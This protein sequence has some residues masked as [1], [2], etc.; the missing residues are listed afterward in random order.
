MS[1]VFG[2]V[3][4]KHWFSDFRE[5]KDLDV[6]SKSGN[7][8]KLRENYWVPTFEEI[9]E[10]NSNPH[11]IDPVFLL[12]IKSAHLGWDIH[13]NKTLNDIIFFKRKGLSMDR[14]LYKK[15][16]KDFT[17]I[18]GKKWASL[19]NKDS[20]TFFQDAVKREYVH[21]DLHEL[22]AVY[23][24]P[25]Y[26]QILK[27]PGTKSVECSKEKFDKL[28]K[29]D[30]LLLVQ[31]EIWVTAL[32]RF[33]IPSDFTYGSNLAY[34]NSFKKLV[35]TMSSNWFKQWII[36]NVDKLVKNKDWTFV[37]KAKKFIHNNN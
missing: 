20:E 9:I 10:R 14:E 15:L 35:T 2:S 29:E 21:D 7:E 28:S 3:A 8:Q 12:T 26:E 34:F 27:Y 22:V 31:E 11:F 13:W 36:D 16:V 5:P 25:L 4:A 19:K 30:K 17:K 32:E 24:R 1:I 37:Q 23:D 18:H 6:I 33:L